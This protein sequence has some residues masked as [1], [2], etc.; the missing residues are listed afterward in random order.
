MI[1][2]K[3]RELAWKLNPSMGVTTR[4]IEETCSRICMIAKSY[5]NC[6]VEKCNGDLRERFE[7][8]SI[9]ENYV[10][11]RT[12]KCVKRIA[13]LCGELPTIDGQHIDPVFNYEPGSPIK[14]VLA[15]GRSD[16]FE[17]IGICV[18]M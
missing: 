10:E 15:D 8:L 13:E 4:Q 7:N 1:T 16:D 12:E 11:E 3:G 6:L 2:K 9:W 17:H 14:L 18:P 5:D